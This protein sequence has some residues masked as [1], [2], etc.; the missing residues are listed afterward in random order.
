MTP[1][2]P[3]VPHHRHRN[4]DEDQLEERGDGLEGERQQAVP[5]LHSTRIIRVWSTLSAA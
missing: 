1:L 3:E 4:R 5:S 2:V